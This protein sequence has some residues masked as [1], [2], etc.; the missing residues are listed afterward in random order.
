V[1]EKDDI[2]TLSTYSSGDDVAY[3]YLYKL[4]NSGN[5]FTYSNWTSDFPKSLEE[6][7][8]AE[9]SPEKMTE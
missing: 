6:I 3:K 9:V 1:S 2:L 7:E 4:D 8:W 5:L